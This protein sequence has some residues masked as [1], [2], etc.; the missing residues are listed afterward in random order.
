MENFSAKTN[1]IEFFIKI[2]KKCPT[3]CSNCSYANSDLD[4]FDLKNVFERID[5]GQNLFLE[6]DF[7][8]FIYGV[9]FLLHPEYIKI[10]DYIKKT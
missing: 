7:V 9:D 1:Y 10:L 8:F 2:G 3:S 6:K 4:Y 5:Y